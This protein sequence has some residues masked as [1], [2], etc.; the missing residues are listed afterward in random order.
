MS[1]WKPRYIYGTY[2]T[3]SSVVRLLRQKGLKARVVTKKDGNHIVE[4]KK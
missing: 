2:K 1:E 3:A 4:V